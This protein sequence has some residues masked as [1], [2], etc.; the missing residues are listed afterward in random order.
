LAAQELP[1]VHV[2]WQ[3]F[4]R[5]QTMGWAKKHWIL[6]NAL[7]ALKDVLTL[8]GVAAVAL[9]LTV[10]GGAALG[11]VTAAG[12]GSVGAGLVVDLF[13]RL[14]MGTVLR[15]A[16]A[17]WRSKRS[18]QIAQHL[19]QHFADPLFL[20]VWKERCQRLEAAPVNRC[21]AACDAL[22]GL[23]QEAARS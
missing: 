6:S 14:R 17:E 20:A 7:S 22:L 12:A 15:E 9:D 16:D 2:D 21:F 8:G 18:D 13:D 19:E 3:E 11:I 4:V 5:Q 1:P 23:G 10:A